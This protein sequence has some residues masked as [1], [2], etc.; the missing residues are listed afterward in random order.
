M[1]R[2][3]SASVLSLCGI[4]AAGPPSA[5][6][7][8]AALIS[9]AGDYTQWRGSAFVLFILWTQ[10]HRGR[11]SGGRKPEIRRNGARNTAS[12]LHHFSALRNGSKRNT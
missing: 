8:E 1:H 7:E 4:N 3:G 5:N 6:G 9:R 2:H 11:F 10:S 12:R